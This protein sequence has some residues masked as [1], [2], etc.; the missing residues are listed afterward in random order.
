MKLLHY[1]IKVALE[2]IRKLTNN[3]PI[4]FTFLNYYHDIDCL[5]R[6]RFSIQIPAS[7]ED[8]RI[9]IKLLIKMIYSIFILH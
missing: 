3:K 7:V 8:E 6:N 9:D 1:E 2:I 4:L 5:I